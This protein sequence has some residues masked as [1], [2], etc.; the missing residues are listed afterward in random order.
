MFAYCIDMYSVHVV[1]INTI[2][3]SFIDLACVG[4]LCYLLT[5]LLFKTSAQVKYYTQCTNYNTLI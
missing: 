1:P 3:Y 4:T 5:Y 2:Y